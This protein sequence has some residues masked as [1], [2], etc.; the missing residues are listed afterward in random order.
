[1]EDL[2]YYNDDGD[3]KTDQRIYEG[4]IQL[5]KDAG[6]NHVRILFDFEYYM[7]EIPDQFYI[8][9]DY[10]D[11]GMMNET[12]L[13]ELDQI[14]AWCMERDIH[15]N[16][17]CAGVVGW[18]D[19][20]RPDS[21]MSKA[22]NAEPLA[23]QWQVLARRYAGIPNTY[24][25]FTLYDEPPIWQDAQLASF[26]GGV[27]EAIR[28]EDPDRCIIADLS[29]KATGESMA[30]LDVALSSRAAL[31]GEMEIDPNTQTAVTDKKIAATAWPCESGRTVYD[32]AA[33]MSFDDGWIQSTP[34][35]VAAVAQQY[36]VGFMVSQW[37]PHMSYGNSTRRERYTDETMQAFLKDMIQTMADRGYS[38]CYGNWFG[39][40][41]FGSAYSRSAAPPIRS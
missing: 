10:P 13:K 38:W 11:E 21:I 31:P 1:M 40:V 27:V 24:L 32:G 18:S 14:I 9:T 2:L 22:K 39:F 30:Q 28:A 25:S 7:S 15:V 29:L 19:L 36:G 5:I 34:D 41:G 4:E 26:F 3:A 6:F 16:L 37:A 12:H 35:S 23:E 8:H 33:T 20:G 17:A